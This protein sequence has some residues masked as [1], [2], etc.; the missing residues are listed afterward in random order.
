VSLFVKGPLDLRGR[1]FIA[2]PKALGEAQ[3]HFLLESL[4][5]RFFT[6]A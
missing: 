3:V 5:F 1:G 2:L 6:I 4:P